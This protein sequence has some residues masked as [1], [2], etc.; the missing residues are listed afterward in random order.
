MRDFRSGTKPNGSSTLDVPRARLGGI[1][2]APEV[3]DSQTIGRSSDIWSLGC[4]LFEVFVRSIGGKELLRETKNERIQQDSDDDYFATK[5]R[6]RSER[7]LSPCVENW[8][9]KTTQID[10][11]NEYET[12]AVTDCKGMILQML[13]FTPNARLVG[14]E[15][16]DYLADIIKELPIEAL[17]LSIDSAS[18]VWSIAE[19]PSL[20]PFSFESPERR[21]PIQVP[22]SLL[23]SDSSLPPVP[24]TE[25]PG[26][27]PIR[28]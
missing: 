20:G 21:L 14:K 6:G 18:S 23:S 22:S 17:P 15:V 16:V 7:I 19:V 13:R 9:Q 12:R 28:E 24:P 26:N 2:S 27:F 5:L 11:L 8:L 25:L 10:H 3:F 1:Y 4:I